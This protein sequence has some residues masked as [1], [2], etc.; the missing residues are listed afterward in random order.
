MSA[1]YILAVG[2]ERYS[3]SEETS[4]S[5]LEEFEDLS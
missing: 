4:C 2:M 5:K 3:G 1:L